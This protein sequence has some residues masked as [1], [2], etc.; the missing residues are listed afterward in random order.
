MTACPHCGEAPCGC[1]QALCCGGNVPG[2]FPH[3]CSTA[4]GEDA[5]SWPY[6][7]QGEVYVAWGRSGSPVQR[8]VHS[9]VLLEVDMVR[10]TTMLTPTTGVTLGLRR[11]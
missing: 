5:T 11:L 8:P 6:T 3:V 9:A 1:H 10:Y 2:I 7:T 4:F